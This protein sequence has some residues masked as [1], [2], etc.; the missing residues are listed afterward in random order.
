MHFSVLPE[1]EYFADNDFIAIGALKAFK[2]AGYRIP[3]DIAIVGF[4]DLPIA[5]YS[6]PMLTTMHVPI[7]YMGILAVERL[8]AIEEDPYEKEYPQN[9]HVNANL[10]VR[11][12][13]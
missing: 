8:H 3:E 12:T 5:V 11:Q 2:E 7:L 6:D 4:D 9:I 1:S 13:A 10:V